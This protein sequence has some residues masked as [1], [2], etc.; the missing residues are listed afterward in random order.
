MSLESR[1]RE[2]QAKGDQAADRIG[3]AGEKP[4]GWIRKNKGTFIAGCIGL[5]AL[6]VILSLL[7][8]R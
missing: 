1:F 8:T 5:C 6:L 2:A 4:V 7:A 3:Q